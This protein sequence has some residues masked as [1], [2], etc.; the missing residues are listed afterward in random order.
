[1]TSK[2]SSCRRFRSGGSAAWVF[3]VVLF[4]PGPAS[5]FGKYDARNREECRA[6]VNANYDALTAR[7]R[8]AGN[9][10]G[11][12]VVNR[13]GRQPDLAACDLME[14]QERERLMMKGYDRLGSAIETL[15]AQR[16]LGAEERRLI[17]GDYETI[18]HYPPAPYREA[19]LERHAEFLRYEQA[20]RAKQSADTTP[21]YRCTD[22]TGAVEF[23]QRPCASGSRQ[24][25]VDIRSAQGVSPST[26]HCDELR[27]HIG[28][29]RKALD[30]AVA[31]LLAESDNGAHGDSDWRAQETRRRAALSN[32]RW[33][34]DQARDAGCL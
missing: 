5:A 24:Q 33:Y 23:T 18:A 26:A 29:S 15:R 27:S 19:Y 4:L 16:P 10:R 11:A 6:Q 32:L 22:A 20:A 3:A 12:E 34:T 21:V 13:K 7:M 31:A 9:S 14:R 8:A 25:A 1:M 30:A 2:R 28:A 17:A